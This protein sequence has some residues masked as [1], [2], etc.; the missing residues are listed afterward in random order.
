MIEFMKWV[1]AGGKKLSG[2]VRRRNAESKLYF[3]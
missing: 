1:N 3:S 2:L